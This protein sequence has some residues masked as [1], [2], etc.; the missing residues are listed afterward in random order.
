MGARSCIEVSLFSKLA[1]VYGDYET[2][3]E[4][5]NAVDYFVI[6]NPFRND[7]ILVSEEDGVNFIF[8][9]TSAHF[10]AGVEKNVND[11]VTYIN[12]VL[13]GKHVNEVSER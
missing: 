2:K 9:S 11:L 12:D 4:T 6:I 5:I 3:I 10:C 7:N 13:D 1:E 8:T